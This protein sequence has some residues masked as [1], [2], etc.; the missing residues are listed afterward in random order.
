MEIDFMHQRSCT[1]F[2]GESDKI[3]YRRIGGYLLNKI[4]KSEL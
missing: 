3:R 2:L 4:F 1:S